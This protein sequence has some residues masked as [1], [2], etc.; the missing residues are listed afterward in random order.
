MDDG[1]VSLTVTSGYEKNVV[2]METIYGVLLTRV[3]L[4]TGRQGSNKPRYIGI[5]RKL[6]GSDTGGNLSRGHV[7]LIDDFYES[8]CAC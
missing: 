5:K 7:K 6:G 3:I 2:V 1:W 8:H 4:I